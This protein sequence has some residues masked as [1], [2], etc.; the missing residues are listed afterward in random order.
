MCQ[1]CARS[2]VSGMRPTGHPAQTGR[3]PHRRSPT[4]SEGARDD[5]DSN[6]AKREI[7]APRES[8]P[9]ERR[10]YKTTPPMPP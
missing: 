5:A 1:V 3:I 8:M 6:D 10:R 2:K 9:P 7:G 4:A